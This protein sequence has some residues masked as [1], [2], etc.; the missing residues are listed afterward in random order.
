MDNNFDIKRQGKRMPYK[1]PE[2][3][4]DQMEENVLKEVSED[5]PAK[6]RKPLWRIVIPSLAAAAAAVALF[7]VLATVKTSRI[8]S[9]SSDVEMAFDN[10]S[11]ED[12]ANF[13][14]SYEDDIFIN[15]Q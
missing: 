13:L 1:V 12:Q 8:N 6:S 9:T 2:G 10:L 15:R 3:F 7:F 5:R 11:A 4:F 14:E